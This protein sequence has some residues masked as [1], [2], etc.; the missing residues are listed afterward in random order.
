MSA[1]APYYCPHCE[2]SRPLVVR[3]DLGNIWRVFWNVVLILLIAFPVVPLKRRCWNIPRLLKP[4]ST[5]F[6]M[7]VLVK[8][9]PPRF[10]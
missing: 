6:R 8:K 9:L 4:A 7:I 5:A 10:I 3:K 1:H 2:S